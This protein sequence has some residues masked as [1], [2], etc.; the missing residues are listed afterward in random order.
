MDNW[1][2]AGVL[3]MG[4][5]I[6]GV[7]PHIITSAEDDKSIVINCEGMVILPAT[8]DYAAPSKS[9][10][11]TADTA[12]NIA[13]LKLNNP[14]PYATLAGV[15]ASHDVLLLDGL[16][17][18]WAGQPLAA[19]SPPVAGHALH[20][21]PADSQRRVGLWVD[22]KD[23]MKQELL[24]TGRYDEGRGDRKSAY[25]SRY[26]IT[27]NR[28]DYLDDLGFWAFGEFKGDRLKP[29]GYRLTKRE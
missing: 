26:W 15:A 6:A 2:R 16:V 25:Q 29:A 19:P 8:V 13:V 10:T 5:V 7:G 21:N 27:G 4:G 17:Q 23:L 14:V 3:I 18:G 28:I 1:E 11:L 24:P 9:S 12:A 20:N 22:G